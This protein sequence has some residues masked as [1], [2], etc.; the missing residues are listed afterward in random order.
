MLASFVKDISNCRR[1]GPVRIYLPALPKGS[2]SLQRK[3]NRIEPLSHSGIRLGVTPR[4]VVR[5]RAASAVACHVVSVG[6]VKQ[7]TAL[8]STDPGQLPSFHQPASFKFK[9]QS[10]N[11]I[12]PRI[13]PDVALA[14][15]AIKSTVIWVFKGPPTVGFSGPR[16]GRRHPDNADRYR[17]PEPAPSC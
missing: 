17:Q 14:L 15:P 5:T 13:L 10:D 7:D 12:D 8:Q 6:R 9:R 1:L 3:A 2:D 11:G 16:T 4:N